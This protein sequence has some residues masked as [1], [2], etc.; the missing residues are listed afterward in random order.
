MYLNIN[1]L[2]ILSITR[3]GIAVI[4]LFFFSGIA[5]ASPNQWD[6]TLEAD[7]QKESIKFGIHP[8]ATNDDDFDFD[9]PAAYPGSPESPYTALQLIDSYGAPNRYWIN[10]NITT[11]RLKVIIN[12]MATTHITWD[13]LTLPPHLDITI[14]GTRITDTDMRTQNSI[15]LEGNADSSV[16]QFFN[17]TVD[18][19]HPVITSVTN[20]TLA[21]E[22]VTITW[23]TNEDSNSTVKYGIASGTYTNEESNSTLVTSHG[24]T[25]TGLNQ[26]TT[27]YYVVNSSDRSGNFNQSNEKSFTTSSYPPAVLT[28]YDPQSENIINMEESARSFS[29]TL[30]Q[31]INVTWYI[32]GTSQQ[33]DT[34]VKTSSYTNNSAKMGYW[35]VSAVTSNE[36]GTLM[37]TWWW[38]VRGKTASI[39]VSANPSPIVANDSQLSTITATVKDSLGNSVIDGTIIT[40]STNR[41]YN[42]TLSTSAATT[43]NGVA[44]ITV[45][46][47]KVGVSNINA[48]NG[49]ISDT[50]DVTMIPGKA[51]IF[52]VIAIPTSIVANN[53]QLSTITATVTDVCGNNVTDGTIIS[54]TSNRPSSDTVSAPTA[55]TT[56]GVTDS[57]TFKGIKSGIS[58][59]TTSNGLASG[60]TDITMTHGPA[61]GIINVSGMDQIGNVY[62]NLPDQFVFQINDQYD[63]PV[64]NVDVKF[65]VIGGNH[66]LAT[67]TTATTGVKGQVSVTLRLGDL[68]G[69]YGIRCEADGTPSMNN[70]IMGFAQSTI[71]S[72]PAGLTNTK[73]NYWV[74]YTWTAGIRG[75][76][77]DSYKVKLNNNWTNGT[78][79]TF[80]NTSVGS[81][82]WADIEVWAYNR[83]GVG[84]LSMDC[85]S[86]LVQASEIPDITFS[87]PTSPVTN[88]EGDQ[89]TFNISINQIVNVSWQVNGLEVHTDINTKQ[90]DYTFRNVKRGV[91]TVSAVVSNKNGTDT[92]TWIWNVLPCGSISVHL[93]DEINNRPILHATVLVINES[94]GEI[95][96]AQTTGQKGRHFVLSVAPGNYTINATTNKY[97]WNNKT[98][99]K[100]LAGKMSRSNIV[101]TP[102]IVKLSLKSERGYHKVCVGSAFL[103][104]HVEFNLRAINYG[105][106]ASFE[107]I[108]SS[109]DALIKFNGSTDPFNFSLDHTDIKDFNVTVNSSKPG[110]YPVIIRVTDGIDKSDFVLTLSVIRNQTGNTMIGKKN[111][112]DQRN[113]TNVSRS[114]LENANV[115][116]CAVISNSILINSTVEENAT[117]KDNSHI[118]NSV[119]K[120]ERTCISGGS[121]IDPSIVDNSIVDSSTVT[122]SHL[123]NS[124]VT[125]S[126]IVNITANGSTIHGV[127]IDSDHN[128]SFT[129]A[130][131]RAD[132]DGRT[133]ILKNTNTKGVLCGV[134]FTSFYA[135]TLLEDLVIKQTNN[136]VFNKNQLQSMDA[137]N[138]LNCYL[139]VNFTQNALIR[140]TETGINP[141]GKGIGDIANSEMIGNFLY[142]QHNVSNTAIQNAAVRI[143]YDASSLT[144]DD[145]SIY[146][147]N[148]STKTWVKCTTIDS[149]KFAAMNWVEAKPNHFSSFVLT[150]ITDPD[151]SGSSSGSD[152][153]ST[154]VSN[155]FTKS[156]PTEISTPTST[157]KPTQTEELTGMGSKTETGSK[158]EILLPDDGDEEDE[159][160]MSGLLILLL[161][162]G[163]AGIITIIF[164]VM[165]KIKEDKE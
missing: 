75:G 97:L 67:P 24:I 125:N 157:A 44:S 55:T 100:V 148:K 146:H 89:R 28:S 25:L 96:N 118:Q 139:T 102:D 108:N 71:P 7:S 130:T 84:N 66:S 13:N 131:V 1:S 103:G 10:E 54:F 83:T 31:T 69:E 26:R 119:V 42:D 126:V 9:F 74:N 163:I 143:Y 36:N 104:D 93:K 20:S 137:S 109:T 50:V 73:G 16:A 8:D 151:D 124:G 95:F 165:R 32:N 116:S 68:E 127:T 112:V 41:T 38:S 77:T 107:V 62:H 45:K 78:K 12:K 57:I 11:W 117:V 154:S 110:S 149:G 145:V 21:P 153:G 114:V 134:T 3:I 61:V 115:R 152:S 63:N 123:I 136:E 23:D 79:T 49:S 58:R 82:G 59:I 64:E 6:M 135:D 85:A 113:C 4:I 22:S 52:T 35:N 142:I 158:G 17:I 101:L 2:N 91:W 14:N 48:S 37:Q 29:I 43:N 138:L 140:I 122:D 86:G 39:S 156:T 27:Y 98:T 19:I 111:K 164:V 56:D 47:E 51:A 150:G 160:G 106:N 161:F 40:F 18:I 34:N 70:T 147:Y 76:I 129:D 162:F 155:I 92:T 87:M 121:I 60:Y 128:I 94:T 15:E 46:G 144:Y 65:T 132:D 72:I 80:I 33:T 88:P 133:M 81:G 99:V 105:K 120:G 30:N 53:T 141:D 90:A 5:I 159:G